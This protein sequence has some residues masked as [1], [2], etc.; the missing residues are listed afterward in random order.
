M[1]RTIHIVGAG[2]A[3]LSAAV[4]LAG[5][6]E[7]VELHEATMHAGG[8]CRSHDDRE[9]GTID[10][11]NHLLLSGNRAALNYLRNIGAETRLRVA[12]S[13]SFPFVDL[14][15]GERWQI[16]LGNGFL[17]LWLLDEKKRVPN[18]GVSDYLAM[19]RLVFCL[20]DRPIGS[21]IACRG[22]AYMRLLKP[23]LTAALNVDPPEGSALLAAAVLRESVM[24]GGRACRPLVV[25]ESLSDT[26]IA[27]A[28]AYLETHGAQVRFGERL[29]GIGQDNGRITTLDFGER[30]VGLGSDDAVIL[31][32]PAY[33]A[34]A[35]VPGLRAPD[36]FRA[37]L[38]FHF[39]A[40]GTEEFPAIT[41]VTGGLSEWVFAY[42][43]RLSVTISNADRLLETPRDEL[44]A[45]VW[46]EV[47]RTFS[48]TMP[49]PRWQI[50]RERRATFAAVP[51]QQAR[52]PH[53]KTRWRNLFLAGDWTDTGLPATIEGAIRSGTRA[54]GLAAAV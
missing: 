35:V 8:R 51:D 11:G 22:A 28:L 26:F 50:V 25:K 49:L 9:I 33:A 1:A 38:N 44:A 32:V 42:P 31:A 16:D 39:R 52:R 2:L 30:T 18:T 6:G 48:R 45:T 4:A 54:A 40:D 29:R 53:A 7:R 13:A 20:R 5:C 19:A 24:A 17:P 21:V 12:H 34:T 15:T 47:C 27:P 23:L 43:G 37:I 46:D 14:A 10:N 36:A 41:G 3:G